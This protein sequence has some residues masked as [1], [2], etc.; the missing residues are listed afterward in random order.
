MATSRRCDRQSDDTVQRLKVQVEIRVLR[1]E[2]SEAYNHV[3]SDARI[4]VS[5]IRSVI[6]ES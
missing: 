6:I 3:P 5:I 4:G 1:L 2:K